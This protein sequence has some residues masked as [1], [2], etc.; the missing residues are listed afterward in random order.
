MAATV[1]PLSPGRWDA[2]RVADAY[3]AH[4]F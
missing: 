1:H 2:A 3:H 4:G